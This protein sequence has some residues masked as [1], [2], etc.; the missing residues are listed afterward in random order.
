MG[1]REQ[2]VDQLADAV[3]GNHIVALRVVE[4]ERDTL[5]RLMT[6]ITDA[7]SAAEIVALVGK[8][9]AILVELKGATVQ[10]IQEGE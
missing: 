4:G 2:M 10:G 6:D 5:L 3:A 1:Q 9:R 8:A 7:R